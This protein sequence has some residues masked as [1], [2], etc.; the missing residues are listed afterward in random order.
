MQDATITQEPEKQSLYQQGKYPSVIDTDDL[1][2]EIGKQVI[3]SLNKE[4]LLDTLLKKTKMLESA[5]VEAN[6][7]KSIAEKDVPSLKL[8]NGKYIENNQRLD[9]ELV[10][11]RK[12]LEKSKRIQQESLKNHKEEIQKLKKILRKRT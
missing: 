12:E 5:L 3:G 2:F 6:E 7:A 10:K 9:T 4:K 1:V 8:S 11:V